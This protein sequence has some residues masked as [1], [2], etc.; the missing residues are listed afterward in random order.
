[1]DIVTELA[2]SIVR[3]EA[4]LDDGS[5]ALLEGL[6]S[7]A[8]PGTIV[9]CMVQ[10]AGLSLREIGEADPGS[11]LGELEGRSL[12]HLQEALR[13]PLGENVGLVRDL[14][15]TTSVGDPGGVVEVAILAIVAAYQA[16]R[17]SDV[18]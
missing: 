17:K 4:G 6:S 9:G 8:D 16:R 10:V 1:M 15:A 11:F 2:E 18:A 12:L 13:R 3:V 7:A 5:A 14:V